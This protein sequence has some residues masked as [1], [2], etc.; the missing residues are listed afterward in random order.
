MIETNSFLTPQ[1]VSYDRNHGPIPPLSNEKHIIR[2]HGVGLNPLELTAGQLR[3]EFRQH[4]VTCA[5]QCAGNRRHTMRTLLKEVQGIDWGDAA[6]MNCKWRGPRLRDVLLH[7][8]LRPGSNNTDRGLHV[9]FSCYKVECQDDE[10]FETS[11][12]LEKCLEEDR[13]AILALEVGSIFPLL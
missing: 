3:S 4:T 2:I 10:F 7:A 8:G 6:V 12:P 13:E 5:L 1:E 9:A 11:V